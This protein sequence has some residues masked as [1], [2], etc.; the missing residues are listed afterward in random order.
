MHTV[1]KTNRLRL[2]LSQRE[3]AR[4]LGCDR[5]TIAAYEGG[6]IVPSLG[7][8]RKMA[9]LFGISLDELTVDSPPVAPVRGRP[10]KTVAPLAP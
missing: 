5:T 8:A 9:Q 4:L 3:L 10:R 2:G 6:K 7:M 1:I